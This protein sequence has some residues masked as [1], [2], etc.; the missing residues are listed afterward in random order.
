MQFLLF[1]LTE[2]LTGHNHFTREMKN[3]MN[4]KEWY[5]NVCVYIYARTRI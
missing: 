4:K 5:L 1:L 2:I 3:T